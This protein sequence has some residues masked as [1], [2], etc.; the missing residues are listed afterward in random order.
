VAELER[1]E[2]ID[3]ALRSLTAA[4]RRRDADGVVALFHD[5]AVLFGS[6]DGELAVGALE[7]REFLARIFDRPGT[8]GWSGWDPVLTGGTQDLA[9]FVAPAT[10]IVRDDAGGEESA[11]YRL[12]GVLEPGS[13]GRWLFR[14]FNGAEPVSTAHE[15]RA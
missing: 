1:V 11:P 10:V 7:I 12:S 4:L 9:W 2:I 14:V 3:N 13:D 6:E 8:Y 5:D 15:P